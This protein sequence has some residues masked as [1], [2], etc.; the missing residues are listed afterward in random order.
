LDARLTV[1][2][3]AKGEPRSEGGLCRAKCLDSS[4]K[5]CDCTRLHAEGIWYM[6]RALQKQEADSAQGRKKDTHSQRKEAAAQCVCV[7]VCVLGQLNQVL[8]FYDVACSGTICVVCK[9]G[10]GSE[11][12]GR[13][14]THSQRKEAA[15][16][17][18]WATFSLHSCKRSRCTCTQA[19][20]SAQPC[21]ICATV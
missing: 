14:E 1:N 10:I 4:I 20:M 2:K 18:A 7:C 5:R 6:V 11:Q 12:G 17:I 9:R 8:Q 21:N 3:G 15:V 19:V 16:Q 13:E